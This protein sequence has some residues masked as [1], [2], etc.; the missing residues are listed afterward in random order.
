MMRLWDYFRSS[1]GYRVRIALGLKGLAV[2]RVPVHLR[3]DGG[4]QRS[5]RYR[6][7]NPAGLVP[8][9]E[10]EGGVLGQ[11]LAIIEYLEETH[12]E[13]PLLPAS[14]L[15][16]AQV[17]AAALA[18]ACDIHPLNNLRVLD[19]MEGP[20]GQDKPARD[21]WYRHWIAEGLGALEAQL[22]TRP[23]GGP[24]AFG[25]A[26]TLADCCLVPQLYNA[27]RFTCPLEA[28]PTLLAIEAACNA[29]PAF[30]AARPERQ[31]DA[32]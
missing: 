4:Q 11:S 17:R 14:P 13:P 23:Q 26:P 3:R 27:R 32:E 6:A 21:A 19:Y 8:A 22:A 5:A 24:Y 2:E 16:R 7:I 31:S 25:A 15:L 30:Q 20:L 1:A 18:V 28:Y 9:L 12:P 10:V 29:L